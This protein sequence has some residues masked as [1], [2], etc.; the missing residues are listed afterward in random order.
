MAFL[1]FPLVLFCHPERSRAQR[2]AIG[3]TESKAPY[4]S[5]TLILGND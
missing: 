4:S 3:S 1:S 2:H 5:S